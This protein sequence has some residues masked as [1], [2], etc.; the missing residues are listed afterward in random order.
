[1]KNSRIKK[2]KFIEWRRPELRKELGIVRWYILYSTLV[3]MF[4]IKQR[5]RIS[6]AV[7]S[8]THVEDFK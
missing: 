5:F 1:M 6:T 3:D 4:G 7:Y 2:I 8:T